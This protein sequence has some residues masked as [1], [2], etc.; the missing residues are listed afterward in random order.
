MIN[1][2]GK[3]IKGHKYFV[4]ICFCIFLG[5]SSNSLIRDYFGITS[6][7]VRDQ[8]ADYF[9][10]EPPETRDQLIED[11]YTLYNLAMLVPIL[12]T[13]AVPF[14]IGRWTIARKYRIPAELEGEPIVIRTDELTTGTKYSF[15]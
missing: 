2:L 12:A 10:E 7:N 1:R 3:F 5:M 9:T 13:A 15:D 14:L 8:L 6:V 4:W 11:T